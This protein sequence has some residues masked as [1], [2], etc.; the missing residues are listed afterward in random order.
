MLLDDLNPIFFIIILILHAWAAIY[1]LRYSFTWMI[2]VSLLVTY[3]LMEATAA[4][5]SAEWILPGIIAILVVVTGLI[6]WLIRRY[7][8]KK[9][10]ETP[11]KAKAVALIWIM[12]GT[13]LSGLQSMPQDS[14]TAMII[15]AVLAGP[16]AALIGLLGNWLVSKVLPVPTSK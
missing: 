4:L 14:E 1:T 16:L 2:S 9:Q 8:I 3:F 7:E 6:W 11:K 12:L 5:M 13:M 15:G 10:R